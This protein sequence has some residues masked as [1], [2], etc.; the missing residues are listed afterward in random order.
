MRLDGNTAHETA[1][2]PAP[3]GKIAARFILELALP[4]AYK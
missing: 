2:N 4:M 3:Q 1:N